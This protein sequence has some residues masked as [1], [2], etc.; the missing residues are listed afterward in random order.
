M[1]IMC[2]V[3]M[4]RA[5]VIN[6]DFVSF[7]KQHLRPRSCSSDSMELAWCVRL[8]KSSP[9]VAERTRAYA[10]ACAS[11]WQSMFSSGLFLKAESAQ[12][13]QGMLQAGSL[14]LPQGWL[15][16]P[17]HAQACFRLEVQVFPRE[18]RLGFLDVLEAGS[19]GFPQDYFLSPRV[20][21]D[22]QAC[23]RLALQVLLRVTSGRRERSSIPASG[24]MPGL[25]SGCYC[26][27]SSWLPLVASCRW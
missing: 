27:F 6:I 21:E 11:G 2:C 14:G 19:P 20:P 18:L 3:F 24:S 12:A 26:R 8:S 10:Q 23:C 5:P 15:S 22:A 7:L 17:E 1:Q 16:S 9:P 25:A 13:R 4:G